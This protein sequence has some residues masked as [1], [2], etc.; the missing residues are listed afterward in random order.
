MS[1]P[2]R[3]AI[4]APS[5]RSL[6]ERYGIF[7]EARVFSVDEQTRTARF[8]AASE[9]RLEGY[10]GPEY[11][12]MAGA[13]FK[14]YSANPV[15]IDTHDRESIA[16][17]I[18]SAKV[19]VEGDKLF[20]D[21]VFTDITQRAREAWELVK[22]NFARALSVGIWITQY[23]ELREGESYQLTSQLVVGPAFI[24]EKWEL[25]EISLVPVPRNPEAV[26][27]YS[28]GHARD[29][30]LERGLVR[31]L[32][33]V[34]NA[35]KEIPMDKKDENMKVELPPPTS[36]PTTNEL[37][38]QAAVLER[39]RA[40]AIRELAPSPLKAFAEGLVLSDK[41]LAECKAILSAKYAELAP[42]AG[43]PEPP[44]P[45]DA[46][47]A[48][49]KEMASKSGGDEPAPKSVAEFSTADIGR[50]FQHA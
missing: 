33:R 10:Y 8:V 45:I 7:G 47:A 26:R 40:A 28:G 12:L 35:E 29:L 34:L 18:G 11:I 24:L 13:D 1:E 30:D 44:A 42:A 50:A 41:P 2:A 9:H 46:R 3:A 5:G 31:V 25:M 21:V 19:S 38:A 17:V 14:R 4:I 49:K 27:V 48:A 20:A 22:S 32:E 43:T 23:K 37:A 39:E 36:G 16:S 6:D 15:V